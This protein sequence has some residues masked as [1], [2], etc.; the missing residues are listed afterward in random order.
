VKYEVVNPGPAILTGYYLQLKVHGR[1]DPD[2]APD[3]SPIVVERCG[4]CDY[5]CKRNGDYTLIYVKKEG[6]A[7]L[8]VNGRIGVLVEANDPNWEPAHVMLVDAAGNESDA[9]GPMLSVPAVSSWR[10]D[11]RNAGPW[12]IFGIAVVQIGAVWFIKRWLERK[13]MREVERGAQENESLGYNKGQK[14][15]QKTISLDASNGGSAIAAK[16][17]GRRQD[18]PGTP[19]P[20]AKNA[21][22]PGSTTAPKKRP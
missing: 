1:F 15:A 4:A 6:N 16:Q 8:P 21:A 5:T 11:V 17:S 2:N 9:S 7:E 22:G 20:A 13:V 3:S 18:Q 14:D 12:I 19:K 10:D